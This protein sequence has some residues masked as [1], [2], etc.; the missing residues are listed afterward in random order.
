M[1]HFRSKSAHVLFYIAQ[2]G[3]LSITTIPHNLNNDLKAHVLS[4]DLNDVFEISVGPRDH[5]D[6]IKSC[7]TY[8]PPDGSQPGYQRQRGVSVLDILHVKYLPKLSKT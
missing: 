2:N 6:G 4:Y 5:Y 7:L 1:F 8:N 3:S